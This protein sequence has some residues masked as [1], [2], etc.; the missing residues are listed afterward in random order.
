MSNSAWRTRPQ[1]ESVVE[2]RWPVIGRLGMFA[3]MAAALFGLFA[4]CGEELHTVPYVP[5]AASEGY[6][7]VVRIES[8]SAVP[9][10]VR[11]MAVDDAG[12]R[13]RRVV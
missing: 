2:L 7:G 12:Q 13:L 5:S 9:G 4:W 8:R 10:E 11:I 6:A 1:S 3:R